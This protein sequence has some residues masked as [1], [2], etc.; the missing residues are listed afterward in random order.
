MIAIEASS[1]T[2]W[3]CSRSTLS[4][5]PRTPSARCTFVAAAAAA[6]AANADL[7]FKAIPVSVLFCR[8]WGKRLLDGAHDHRELHRQWI[9][10]TIATNNGS[11]FRVNTDYLHAYAGDM[12]AEFTGIVYH[13]SACVWQWTGND[14]APLGLSQA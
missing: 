4:T 1:H 14:T 11:Q 5:T 6:S 3:G 9:F 10:P 12:K 7:I 2:T 8:G 13:E